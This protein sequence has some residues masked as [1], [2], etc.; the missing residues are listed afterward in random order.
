[1]NVDHILDTMNR[2]GVEYLLIG[3]MNFLLRHQPVLTF[4]V[5]LWINDTPDNLARCESALSTLD[6]SWG[7]SVDSW[8]PVAKLP[9]GWLSRQPLFC[10]VT[11]SGAVDI[12]RQVSG[13]DDW[14]ASKRRA[15][16]EKTADG[17]GYWGLCDKDMLRCQEAL[18]PRVQKS[19]RVAFLRKRL[20]EE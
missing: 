7:Q 2:H 1:M 17:V 18:D 3:G 15:I 14:S 12:F 20:G 6:A 9:A 19:A 10:L 11:P 8:G 13:L 16:G 4:D 5:D